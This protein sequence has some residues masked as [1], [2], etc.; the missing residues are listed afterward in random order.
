MKT[1]ITK[2]ICTP[3]FITVLFPMTKNGSN[4][5]KV[6]TD[7]WMDEKDVVYIHMECYVTLQSLTIFKNNDGPGGYCAKT[8]NDKEWQKMT[9]AV[10]NPRNKASEQK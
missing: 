2:D 4:P 9:N 8:Q 7:R 1:L 3:V 6:C 10:C 5:K